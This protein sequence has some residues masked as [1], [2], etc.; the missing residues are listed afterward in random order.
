MIDKRTRIKIAIQKSGRL[1]D[2]SLDLLERCGLKYTRGRDQLI[3]YGENMPVDLLF[4]RDDDIPGLVRDD[5]CDLGIAGLNIIEEKRLEFVS[6]GITK[7][8][9]EVCRLDYGHCRL[10]FGYPETGSI[11][12]IQDLKGSTI[13]TSYPFILRDF[14]QQKN[15]PADVIE[16]SGAVEIA[17]SLGRADV[18]CDLVSTGTTMAANKIREGETILDSECILL[19][20]PVAISPEKTEWVD[21][22]QQRIEGV[23][24]VR[25]SKYIMMHAPKVALPDIT[26]LL[27]GAESPTVL[28]LEGFTDKVAI[29]VVCRENIFWETL[30]A[31]KGVGA[32]S[33]L[34]LPV[35]KM[36]A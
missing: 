8:Y 28:P 35:E 12:T 13:A 32:S 25:E 17:P 5:V 19:K 10:A 9:I 27:P 6:E 20:T 26:A 18:I 11:Q 15:I 21:R 29:H 30:E 24:Q 33:I 1:T 23:M 22:L 2:H 7:P 31:L 16:F 4:V 3:G 36:L 14:L 34:V